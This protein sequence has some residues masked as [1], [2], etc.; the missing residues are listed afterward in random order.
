[1]GL[2]LYLYE[3]ITCLIPAGI[4][5]VIL[6]KKTGRILTARSL[7]ILLLFV[8]YLSAVFLVTGAG[9]LYDVIR[10][11]ITINPERINLIPFSDAD[12][13]I[14]N[15]LNVYLFIPLGFFLPLLWYQK[16]GL[17]Y[18]AVFGF[19]FS[20]LIEL[21]QLLDH[22]SSDV[23]DLIM[24]TSGALI[25]FLLYLLY[26]RIRKRKKQNR[27]S[28]DF[29][30]VKHPDVMSG[31]YRSAAVFILVIFLFR[32]FTYDEFFA[33]KILYGF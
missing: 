4:M 23:D 2:L 10:T 12:I 7:I 20:L 31:G 22:R 1:M 5:V 6:K 26:C 14:F 15:E 24:N 30:T 29:R 13:A 16:K 19:L 28:G 18:T 9:T 3:L 33:A 25:G 21:S 11:G 27:M 17:L 8:V 32:F